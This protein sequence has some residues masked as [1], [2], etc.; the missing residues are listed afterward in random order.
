M[1][2]HPIG[3]VTEHLP[4]PNCNHNEIR[5]KNNEPGALPDNGHLTSAL[6]AGNLFEVLFGVVRPSL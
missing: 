2:K 5:I 3:D 4:T 6:L 1:I